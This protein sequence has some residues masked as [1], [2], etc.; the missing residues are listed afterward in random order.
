MESGQRQRVVRALQEEVRGHAK[1]CAQSVHPQHGVGTCALGCGQDVR[2]DAFVR[3]RLDAAENVGLVAHVQRFRFR[4]AR[5]GKVLGA[6]HGL[7]GQ[8]LQEFGG[9][10]CVHVVV[11]AEAAGTGSTL[12][13]SAYPKASMLTCKG[14]AT[15]VVED[16]RCRTIAQV[17]RPFTHDDLRCRRPSVHVPIGR[18]HDLEVVGQSRR[19][20]VLPTGGRDAD[21]KVDKV[22]S[23]EV[24]CTWAVADTAVVER[25]HARS[26]SS[27]MPSS[28]SSARQSPSQSPRASGKKQV[29]SLV[30]AASS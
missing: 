25:P 27:Q 12:T 3:E 24:T 18:Q 30:L 8:T 10:Y 14:V 28:S 20:F 2:R 17:F 13:C 4:G 22:R 21:G 11:D 5:Q 6:L 26:L 19:K 23:A 29:P 1:L 16:E 7:I 9:A 15:A